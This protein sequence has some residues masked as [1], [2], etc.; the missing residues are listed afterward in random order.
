MDANAD[1]QRDLW[2]DWDDI[3]ASV[4]N[5]LREYGW[6]PGAPVLAETRLEPDPNFQIEPRNLQLNETVDSLSA[7]GVK[8][9]LDVP[10]DT[11]ALLLSAEQPDGPAY[12]V[13][14]HNFYCD[15]PLQRQR[16]LRHG[17]VRPGP[18]A[19]PAHGAGECAAGRRTV[20]APQPRAGLALVL[21]ALLVGGCSMVTH[22]PQRA[23]PPPPV[24]TPPPPPPADVAAVPD[25]VPRAEARSAHGNPPFYDVL[26]RRYF[27]LASAEGYV[28]RGVAS[29]YGPGFHGGSTS[30]GEAYDMYAMTA[31]HKTLP[32]PCYARVTN[33]RNGRAWW[34]ASTTAAR[35]SPIASST[36]RT[37]RPPGST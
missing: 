6:K 3:F 11:P 25:A 30:S 12:R 37:P 34:C 29:W 20:I 7:H 13:G 33:L 5:Y 9:L 36:C 22:H 26:G 4:A 24:A 28:E 17:R 31:A 35:S 16:P 10:G 27:V 21:G 32:L 1:R 15:H 8:V 23:L 2:N 19:E 18:G 14:F